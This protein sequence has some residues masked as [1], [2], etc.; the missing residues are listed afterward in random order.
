MIIYLLSNQI[1][2]LMENISKK[3][4]FIVGV[5]MSILGFFSSCSTDD[6]ESTRQAQVSENVVLKSGLSLEA[7]SELSDRID[8]KFGQTRSSDN[9]LTEQEA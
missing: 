7:F 8:A 2:M 4:V 1:Y 9:L 6:L 3:S 5:V